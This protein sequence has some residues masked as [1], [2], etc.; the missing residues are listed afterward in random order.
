STNHDTLRAFFLER[1]GIE[2][3]AALHTQTPTWVIWD[4]WD[5]AGN[6][7]DGSVTG[8]ETGLATFERFWANPAMGSG[9]APG[10]WHSFRWGDVEFFMLDDRYHRS[11]A[12]GTM[13][14]EAQLAWLMWG[15][16][17]STATFKVMATGVQW[18]QGSHGDTWAS[19][20]DEWQLIV[21][22]IMG[23]GIDG[24]LTISGDV[25]HAEIRRI[26]E[27]SDTAY[28]LWETTSSPLAN[29][30]GGCS[31]ANA[32]EALIFCA[33]GVNYGLMRFDTAAAD[34]TVA[35]EIHTL[36]G[37]ML[38]SHTLTLS[39]LSTPAL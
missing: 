14:G 27:A 5:Y 16:S 7:T 38:T 11:L 22:H 26:T 2:S 4:D 19:Y 36:E 35:L 25:H 20:S 39:E 33:T 31:N 32:D 29:T 10:V 8:K 24:V 6:N 15:L 1:H 9:G 12:A 23:Q 34:P 17:T 21:D 30:S 13:L 18:Y 3:V 28:P 37:V